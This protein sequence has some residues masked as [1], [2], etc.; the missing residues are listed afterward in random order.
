MFSL[1]SQYLLTPANG[2]VDQP[3]NSHHPNIVVWN[4][5]V[6]KERLYTSVE[7]QKQILF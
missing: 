2:S 1:N 3:V 6:M 4:L 7:K 5:D